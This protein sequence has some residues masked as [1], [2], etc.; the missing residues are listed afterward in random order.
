MEA[1]E[2]YRVVTMDH[3]DIASRVLGTLEREGIR[4]CVIGGQGV[5]AYAD[6]LV[7][8]DLDLAVASDDLARLR[9]LLSLEFTVEEFP[10][11]LNV[12][13]PGSALRIQFQLDP[14]YAAFVPS[15]TRREVLGREMPVARIEDVFQ[16]KIWA[17]L[18][19]GR[20]PSKRQKDLA[21]ISRLLEVEPRLEAL[22]P[23]EVLS[24]LEKA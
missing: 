20:R 5:N 12:S 4:F 8:L 17:V 6:P 16:G 24:R 19:P 21:D 23:K 9:K 18:D 1:V 3:A 2:F 11:S 7:S 13:E 10:H 15:A 14:R 22:A